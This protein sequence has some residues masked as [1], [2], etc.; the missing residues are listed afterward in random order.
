ME[1]KE[2]ETIQKNL[3]VS[4]APS[5]I[6][7][8]SKKFTH[9]MGKGNINSTM[10]LSAD[11][12][13]NGILPLNDQTL[14]QTKQK[15]PHGKE[16]DPWGFDNRYTRRNLSYQILFGRFEF[17]PTDARSVRKAI[18]ETKGA[19]ISPDLDADS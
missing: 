8:M 19:P 3:R 15:H 11:N 10:K 9:D 6:A 17:H 1:L 4:N 2:A 16:A 7:E 18:L 12:M 13:Q 5:T 14:Y